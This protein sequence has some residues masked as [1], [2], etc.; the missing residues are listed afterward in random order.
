MQHRIVLKYEFSILGVVNTKLR[1]QAYSASWWGWWLFGPLQLHRPFVKDAFHGAQ[2]TLFCA[3]DYGLQ[4]MAARADG[5]GR[6]YVNCCEARP[7]A[8]AMVVKDCKRLW[9]LSEYYLGLK[10]SNQTEIL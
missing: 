1:R 10:S 3:L 6:Y 8:R 9:D 4:E 7:S 5:G 2:T